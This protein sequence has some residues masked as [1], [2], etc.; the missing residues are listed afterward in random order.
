MNSSRAR[1][2]QT[3]LTELTASSEQDNTLDKIPDIQRDKKGRTLPEI[4]CDLLAEKN[5]R[6]LDLMLEQL[7][8]GLQVKNS[9]MRLKAACY[10]TD[11]LEL[12]IAHQEWRH[13]DRLLPAVERAI[14]IAVEN[15]IS[16][17]QIITALSAFAAYQI[18]MGRYASARKGLQ[19]FINPDILAPASEE[20]R[21]QVVQLIN[22]LATQP[23]MEL[24]LIEY[25]YDQD[26]GIDAG[27]L[28]TVFGRT[29]AEFLIE[30]QNLQQSKEK[31]DKLLKLFEE[32]GRPAEDSLC[33][34]LQG[35][36]TDWY[37]IRNIIRLLG[38]KGSAACFTDMASFLQH[39]DIRVKGEVLRAVSRI[40][41][42]GKKDFFLKA[43]KSVP[44]QLTELVVSLLGDIPDISLV[45]PLVDLLD[46]AA[47]VKNKAGQTLQIAVCQSLGKI[48]SVKAVPTLKKVIAA[49]T[50]PENAMQKQIVRVAE[51]AI[52]LINHGGKHKRTGSPG[53]LDVPVQNNPFAAR[54]SGIIRTAMAGDR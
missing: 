21:H 6:Q 17:W 42:G 10:L 45:T 7:V 5:N 4:I 52:Q 43:L 36:T 37:L 53:N 50:K 14:I 27:M 16:V 9:R 13:L 28:L 30:P 31:P 38:E 33:K 1:E 12:L 8:A 19:I 51:Q 46:E 40:D 44:K 49:N 3:N 54:E 41:A 15:D 24:L 20:L 35:R 47:L 34:M 48:G 23:L 2:A 22:D 25:L 11:T 39:D 26:K 32:I 29:A 18:E